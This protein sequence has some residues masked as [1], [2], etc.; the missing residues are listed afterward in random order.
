VAWGKSQWGSS[1]RGLEVAIDLSAMGE[2]ARGKSQV[3]GSKVGW[4]GIVMGGWGGGGW[5]SQE[6]EQG[7]LYPWSVTLATLAS[8][9]QLGN[10]KLL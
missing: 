8:G 10:V 5:V 9:S 2:V 1:T 7:R 4:R 6:S 3:G